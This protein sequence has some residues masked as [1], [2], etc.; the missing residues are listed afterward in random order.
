M[1]PLTCRL[2]QFELWHYW[3]IFA[4]VQLQN[5][6]WGNLLLLSCIEEE[7][8][9]SFDKSIALQKNE[10]CFKNISSLNF[11]R[12]LGC[13]Q[14]MSNAISLLLS[15]PL[16]SCVCVH[17]DLL[18]CLDH[19]PLSSSLPFSQYL[20]YSNKWIPI[21]QMRLDMFSMVWL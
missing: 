17:C 12:H 4:A 2:T 11:F 8:L 3:D 13:L 14:R 20:L 1:V 5:K 7:K 16:T 10:F 9:K 19:F 6:V 21:F 18:I 15:C